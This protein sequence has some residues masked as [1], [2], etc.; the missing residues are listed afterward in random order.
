[1]KELKASLEKKISNTALR[2]REI[3]LCELCLI[4]RALLPRLSTYN[5]I[6]KYD[7]LLSELGCRER[8]L[9][10]LLV[11]HLTIL[12]HQERLCV[13]GRYETSVE[14]ILQALQLIG[15]N[16]NPIGFISKYYRLQYEALSSHFGQSIFTRSEAAQILGLK[17]TQ[18]CKVLNKLLSYS[19]LARGQYPN[20]G[21]HYQV[22]CK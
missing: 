14:D 3:L 13:K 6:Q 5:P 21:Y 16:H 12:H 10:N 22:I 11:H 19:L 2:K 20:R 8:G 18:T 15:P 4:L 17:K 9:Y 1:M 7:Y